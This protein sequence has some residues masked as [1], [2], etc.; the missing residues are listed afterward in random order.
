MVERLIA[1]IRDELPAD[2]HQRWTENAKWSLLK[3][4]PA[5]AEDY[6]EQFDLIVATTSNL[7]FW[8][9]THSAALFYDERFSRTGE[10]FAY[11]K[12]HGSQGLDTELF[13][14]KAEIEDA[15]DAVLKP[16]GLGCQIGGGTG[17]RYSYIDLA[18]TRLDD[19]IRA[20]C[21]RLRASNV[22]RRSWIQFYNADL[23]NEWVG[24]YADSPAPPMPSAKDE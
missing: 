15:V 23:K 16:S 14:D 12:L 22:P 6:P 11:I 24:V 7:P 3:L 10:S 19:A 2:D 21:G 18:L 9:A 5:P 4:E 20:V 13:A 17:L 1:Q 8:R